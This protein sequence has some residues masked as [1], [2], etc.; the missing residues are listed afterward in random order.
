MFETQNKLQQR[1]RVKICGITRPEDA[2]HAALLGVDAIGLV[3]YDKS[4]RAVSIQQAH[5]ILQ[6]LPP[7]VTT[8]GLFVNAEPSFVRDTLAQIPLDILQFHG[9]ETPAYCLE[10]TRPYIK[11]LRMQ[12]GVD[13]SAYAVEHQHAQALLLDSYVQGIKGGTGIVFD[14]Q[15][16]PSHI[17]KPIIIAGGLRPENV[18]QVITTLHPYAIDV[19]GG[20]ESAKGIKDA[21][22]MT[23]FMKGVLNV[24]H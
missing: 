1:T 9:E 17:E 23:A 4:P 13:V 12:P 5:A 14:W 3:F 10:F 7:F 8:V 11:A 15:Q 16:V 19:S 20:V 24:N 21:D 6:A 22:K 2:Q 18:N